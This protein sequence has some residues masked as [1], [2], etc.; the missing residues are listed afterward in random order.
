MRVELKVFEL[1]YTFFKIFFILKQGQVQTFRPPDLAS[2]IAEI[3]DVLPFKMICQADTYLACYYWVSYICFLVF[4]INFGKFLSIITFSVLFFL[5]SP[6]DIPRMHGY[7]FWNYACR[8]P[9]ISLGFSRWQR[10]HFIHFAFQLESFHWSI[11]SD[12]FLGHVHTLD[13]CIKS[14]LHLS[15]DVFGF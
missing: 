15:C 13:K 4:V 2:Q 10:S 5:C 3:I 6:S 7:P 1:N 12:S 14:F 9:V 11:V 8:P